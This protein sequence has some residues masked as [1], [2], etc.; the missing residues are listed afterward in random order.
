MGSSDVQPR[1]VIDGR[2]LTAGR[3]G[4]GRYLDVLLGAWE[5]DGLP[6]SRGVLVLQDHRVAESLPRPAGLDIR[7][8][9]ANWPGLAW[10]TFALGRILRRGDF[11]FAPANWVPWS[12]RGRTLLVLHDLIQFAEPEAFS[13]RIRWQYGWRYRL[14]A[15][16]AERIVTPSAATAAD[17]TRFLGV[18]PGRLRVIPPGV[19]PA[20]RHL[21]PDSPEVRRVRGHFGLEGDPYFLF[22]GKATG[23]RRLPEVMRAVAEARASGEAW[24]LVLVGPCSSIDGD[25][26][27]V[28]KAGHLPD[29]DVCALMNGAAALLYPSSYEGFGLPVVE[30]MASG[31]P[32]ITRRNSALVESAGDAAWFLESADA[33]AIRRAMDAICKD[34]ALRERMIAEGLRQSGKFSDGRFARE[35]GRVIREMAQSPAAAIA[36]SSSISGANPRRM[37]FSVTDRAS[38][39]SRR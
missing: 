6:L 29:E 23:R 7:I 18:E 5:V 28:V 21:G 35:I 1:L 36:S 34:R 38:M 24:R 26:P 13:R 16:R 37:V 25:M 27:G 39:N 17:A 4:V 12:W 9:G 2:R 3:T 33:G 32:V 30:A 20:F 11:L 15:R 19:S 14:A 31:C 8:L 10:E 22:V